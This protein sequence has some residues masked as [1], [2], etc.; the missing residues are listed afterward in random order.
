[1][2]F[3]FEQLR[4]AEL[5]LT[6]I[7]TEGWREDG[8]LCHEEEVWIHENAFRLYDVQTTSRLLLSLV[9]E[10]LDDVVANEDDTVG[11]YQCIQFNS[12]LKSIRLSSSKLRDKK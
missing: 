8:F 2:Y 6:M 3:K 1:M 7:G 9:L 10:N 11:W 5:L 4:N 12:H